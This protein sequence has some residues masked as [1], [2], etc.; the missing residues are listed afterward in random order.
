[1]PKICTDLAILKAK[2]RPATK[3]DLKIAERLEK[4]LVDYNLEALTSGKRDLCAGMAADMIGETA[5]IVSILDQNGS[6]L[7]MLNPKI[8]KKETEIQTEEGCLCHMG[9]HK[10]RRYATV[11]VEFKTKRFAD[12]RMTLTG[13]PAIALQHEI[14]HLNGILI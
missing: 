9:L 2:A 1:M 4:T 3:K 12:K 13:N 8:V 5:A 11:V 6:P 10:A 14:D 7:T